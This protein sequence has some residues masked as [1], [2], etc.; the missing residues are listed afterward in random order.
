MHLNC[1]TTMKLRL[2]IFIFSLI[3]ACK[4]GKV[5]APELVAGEEK[6]EAVLLYKEELPIEEIKDFR[7]SKDIFFSG[8]QSLYLNRQI[9]FSTGFKL[10]IGRIP[11]FD[12]ADSLEINLKYFTNNKLKGTKVVWTIDDDKGKNLVWS[13]S[14]IESNKVS[15]WNDVKLGFKLNRQMLQQN[16]VINIY[17]W[18]PEKDE[19]WIDDFDFRLFG[20]DHMEQTMS[21]LNSNFYY[22]FETVQDIFRPESIKASK[23]HSGK[24]TCNLSDG[25]EY[26]IALKKPLNLFGNAII[27]KIAA[28]IWVYPSQENHDLILIFSCTDKNTGEVKFW[29]GKSTLHGEFELNKWTKLNFSTNLPVEKFNLD[30]E[31]EIA[32]WNRG[33]TSILVDD[34]HIV[35]GDHPERKTEQKIANIENNNLENTVFL[36]QN[37][38]LLDTI[39]TKFLS[40]YRPNDIVLAGLFYQPQNEL[41][42]IIHF[43]KERVQMSCFNNKKK[44]F[45]TIWETNDK[46]HPL[47]ESNKLFFAGDFDHDRMSEILIVNK[48]NYTWE[49]YHFK[50]GNWELKTKGMQAFPK[51]WTLRSNQIGVSNTILP[52]A[53]SVLFNFIDENLTILEL[54]D[55]NWSLKNNVVKFDNAYMNER[56]LLLD[57]NDGNFLKLNQDWRFDLKLLERNGANLSI[58]KRIEFKKNNNGLS[59]K[60]FEYTHLLSGNF[61]SSQ[62]KHLLAFYFN[63]ANADYDGINCTKI[64]NNV[65]FPNGISFYH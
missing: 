26:G 37:V 38:L 57:W 45:E 50:S 49:L 59:P 12:L 9:E 58:R 40:S 48:I 16:S 63:C 4:N 36:D 62:S 13:G 11:H 31:I 54:V 42:S 5:K 44:I 3:V 60:Y 51:Q 30:D 65:E 23:A 43:Q 32:I 1:I 53:K 2:F 15:A 19:I 18:N 64:E 8:K 33:K 14:L 47:L 10:N 20:L 29:N 56:G 41:E 46:K 35:F 52:S 25:K 21:K 27:K 6:K 24:M 39:S 34:L 55:G 28:S 22:D 17:V 7:I 61:I